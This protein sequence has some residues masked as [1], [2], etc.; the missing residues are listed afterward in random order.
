[1]YSKD[2]TT[3]KEDFKVLT[4]K[5]RF[6]IEHIVCYEVKNIVT[7][8]SDGRRMQHIFTDLDFPK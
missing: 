3:T 4:L 6:A 1:M 2:D 7:N 5:M 8:E